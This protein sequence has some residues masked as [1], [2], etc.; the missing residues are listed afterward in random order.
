MTPTVSVIMAAYNGAGLIGETIATLR[1]QRFA[2]WELVVVDDC[3][4][5]ATPATIRA[6]GD[7]RI[8]LFQA[9]ENGGPVKARNLAFA[10]ARGRYVAGLDHDDLCHPDRFARQVAYLDA[11]P[12]TVL[13]ATGATELRGGRVVPSQL[14]P[15]TRPALLD[16]LLEIQ[17][18]LVWSSVLFRADAARR[19]DPLTRPQLLYAEDFDFYHRLRGFG[20]LARLDETLV[21]YRSHPGG[22]SQ[23]QA[24]RM[25]E[26]ATAVLAERYAALFGEEGAERAATVVRHVMGRVAVPDGATLARLGETIATLQAA[27]IARTGVG[28]EDLALIRWETARLWARIGRAAL[29]SGTVGIGAALKARPDHLGLGYAGLDDLLTGQLIG[30]ARN[31]VRRPRA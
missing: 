31:L 6:I 18:P 25:G 1:A 21:T 24:A 17:N 7:P 14:P 2:D 23:R 12:A 29:R 5:D 13:V 11:N 27:H 15:V 20:T 10:H 4:T 22:L 28:G 3:S 19:L 9:P 8:R 26:S 16:W 30:A